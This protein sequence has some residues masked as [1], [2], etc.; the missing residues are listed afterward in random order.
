MLLTENHLAY[1]VAL[2]PEG[3][4][5]FARGVKVSEGALGDFRVV[6]RVGAGALA[7]VFVAVND[8]GSGRAPL[9]AIK[10]LRARYAHDSQILRAFTHDARAAAGLVHPNIVPIYEVA[11]E[12]GIP[13][14][15]ME[16]VEGQPLSDLL[17]QAR[18]RGISFGP[19]LSAHI[20]VEALAGLEHA[21]EHR[22]GALQGVF[23]RDAGPHNLFVT[24]D[25]Q[26]KLAD[27]G[28]G[29]A[30]LAL[31]PLVSPSRYTAPEHCLG[32]DTAKSDARA[33][34]YAVGLVLWELLTGLRVPPG[35]DVPRPS[36][37]VPR[38]DRQLD[39]IAV[40][41]AESSP[42]RRFASAR[43]MREAL[44]AYLS[45]AR[46]QVSAHDV[47]HRMA[48]LTHRLPPTSQGAPSAGLDAPRVVP[49]S[50]TAVP[51]PE[52]SALVL[53]PTEYG[54]EP[55]E[56]PRG[57][58]FM[59]AMPAAAL[60][61]ATLVHFGLSFLP[62]RAHTTHAAVVVPQAVIPS[63]PPPPPP[64]A[65][66]PVTAAPAPVDSATPAAPVMPPLPRRTRTQAAAPR[67][68]PKAEAPSVDGA[69]AY[70]TLDTIPWT[71]VSEGGRVLGTTPLVR[72]AMT[73][74]SHKLTLENAEEG[75]KHTYT[76]TLKSG[77]AISRRLGL[78]SE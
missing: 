23:H 5:P 29:G 14:I 46:V 66:A 16:Y 70:L 72:E 63:P 75:V 18:R 3:V 76:V 33:D 47:A 65:V 31:M 2:T 22:D 15:A 1:R 34:T 78:K 9:A 55:R 12:N 19:A 64:S 4:H 69:R 6:A 57:L 54:A 21:H 56:N 67:S 52:E 43:E 50:Q 49:S 61:G 73:A 60:L 24:Y 13:F 7:E 62:S 28:V 17:E 35:L 74:G 10:R 51:E 26:V 42:S 68:I 38:I 30:R 44:N 45:Q 8:D 71:R 27:F 59:W 58:F 41:A 39:A 37:I 48:Q 25:G 40:R 32:G 36:T 20:V 53:E 77:E 11:Q